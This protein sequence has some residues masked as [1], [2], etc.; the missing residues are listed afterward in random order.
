MVE[1]GAK[2][3]EGDDS[4]AFIRIAH[5]S[6]DQGMS[7]DP[8][9]AVTCDEGAA[10][11]AGSIWMGVFACCPEEQDGCTATFHDFCIK[12][13]TTFEHNADGN[14][15]GPAAAAGGAL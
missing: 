11:P 10:A 5:L 14:H 8:L 13:G 3:S 15:E 2:G 7:N 4:L 9:V 6:L 12:K 1:A